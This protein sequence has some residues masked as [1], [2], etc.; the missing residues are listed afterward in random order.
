[1]SGIALGLES[2]MNFSFSSRK[3]IFDFIRYYERLVLNRTLI[4][5]L[6][7]LIS[8]SMQ[9]QS[10]LTNFDF[11]FSVTNLTF[12]GFSTIIIIFRLHYITFFHTGALNHGAGHR[13][14]FSSMVSLFFLFTPWKYF[15]FKTFQLQPLQ[16][17]WSPT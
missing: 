2:R 4:F 13:F 8:Y 17:E 7:A 6:Q 12:Y 5:I 14:I 15:W 16:T 3:L 9:M 1:M 10:V 11:F